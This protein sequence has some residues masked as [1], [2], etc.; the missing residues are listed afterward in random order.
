VGTGPQLFRLPD[1]RLNVKTYV[2][3]AASVLLFARSGQAQRSIPNQQIDYP[4]FLKSAHQVEAIRESRR[5]TERQF[6][7]MMGEPG[8]VL[9]DARSA[10]KF[11]L[12][13]LKGAVNL[14]L[15]DFN[16]TELSRIIPGKDTKVLIY[17]NNNFIN[18]PVSFPT[19]VAGASLNISTF[20]TLSTYG[21]SNVYELGPLI[22]VSRSKLPFEG[23][24]LSSSP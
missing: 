20:V 15:P 11:K 24:E 17:C 22:D 8:V 13:H 19:K 1:V 23:D 3:I 12:R 14:S 4:A 18:S 5:L 21:Y 10:A 6:L 2:L 9:L 16:A 7:Q